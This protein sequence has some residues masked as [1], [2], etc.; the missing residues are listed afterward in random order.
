MNE[1]ITIEVCYCSVFDSCWITRS[2]HMVSKEVQ[3]CEAGERT[4]F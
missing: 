3:A 2:R 4:E 1:Q